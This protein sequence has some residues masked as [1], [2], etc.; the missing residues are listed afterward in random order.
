M[1]VEKRLVSLGVCSPTL[2]GESSVSSGLGIFLA[3]D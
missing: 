3:A 2:V 1:G